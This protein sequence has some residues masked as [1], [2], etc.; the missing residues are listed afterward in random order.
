[1][2]AE[3]AIHLV[4]SPDS[5]TGKNYYGYDITFKLLYLFLYTISLLGSSELGAQSLSD[6]ENTCSFFIERGSK[7]RWCV[8]SYICI[9]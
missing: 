7:V 6:D 8:T 2:K 3:T 9:F 5:D 4:C 1:M